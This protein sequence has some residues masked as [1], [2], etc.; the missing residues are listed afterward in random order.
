[1]TARCRGG[2]SKVK[3]GAGR[4]V[5]FGAGE[6]REIGAAFFGQLL[7]IIEPKIQDLVIH[8]VKEIWNYL[9]LYSGRINL[10]ELSTSSRI[11]SG[12]RM[13]CRRQ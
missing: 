9:E 1:M 2:G 5:V 6:N 3:G 8:T 11:C 7:N 10:K 13:V 4:L 12:V